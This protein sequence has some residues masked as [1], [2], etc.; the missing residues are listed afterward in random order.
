[1]KK[2][3]LAISGCMGRMGQQLIKSC[4][5]NKNFRLVSLTENR[6]INKKFSG[7]KPEFNSLKAFEGADVLIDFTV[8]D[9]TFEILKIAS[10]LKKKLLLAQ[11]VLLR[12]KKVKLKNIQK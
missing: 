3:N 2:I 9:C 4:K 6:S 11:L 12:N 10:K 1:M 7:I 8:P 5:K